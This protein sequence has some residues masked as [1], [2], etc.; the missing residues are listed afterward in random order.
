MEKLSTLVSRAYIGVVKKKENCPGGKKSVLAQMNRRGSLESTKIQSRG[1]KHL[2]REAIENCA[3]IQGLFE[4][5]LRKKITC[6]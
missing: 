2:K 4:G 6:Y 1:L 5:K 3:K